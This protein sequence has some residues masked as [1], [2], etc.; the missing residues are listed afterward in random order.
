[1]KKVF[2]LFKYLSVLVFTALSLPLHAEDSDI[3][4]HSESEN[5][6]PSVY[7]STKKRVGDKFNI[8]SRA[9]NGA[10]GVIVWADGT[11]TPLTSRNMMIPLRS[12]KFKIEGRFE[13]LEVPG[14]KL[15]SLNVSE[16]KDLRYL[17]CPNNNL[18]NLDISNNVSLKELE[19][20]VNQI[21]SIDVSHNKELTH[22]LIHD[23]RLDTLDL[24]G[25]TKLERLVANSNLLKS[26]DI[27]KNPELSFL[28][29][30]ANQISTLVMDGNV[31]YSKL[32]TIYGNNNRLEILDL[33]G[34]PNL[35]E[36][37]VG[38]NLLRK[39]TLGNNDK[40]RKFQFDLN[41]IN[42]ENMQ[43]IVNS[44]NSVDSLSIKYISV[45]NPDDDNEGNICP[46][47]LVKE[48]SAKHWNVV[49]TNWDG[50]TLPFDGNS[51][52][53]TF[54]VSLEFNSDMGTISIEGLDS[55]A[56]AKVKYGTI[57]HVEAKGTKPDY[58]LK[59]LEANKTDILNDMQFKV[60]G[61]MKVVG[62]FSDFTSILEIAPTGYSVY[63]N[64]T[65]DY[66][67]IN[68]CANDEVRIFDLSGLKLADFVLDENG[69]ARF[70]F[71]SFEAGTYLVK[72]GRRILKVLVK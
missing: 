65:S 7:V 28:G 62:E 18:K 29:I 2:S 24:S 38:Q 30:R 70:D 48:L 41:S 51:P 34:C 27:S 8:A 53:D 36:V 68:G 16:Q 9:F 15:D 31:T 10:S 45:A 17:I 43:S 58:K 44:L 13:Y 42:E 55:E 14:N 26:L 12:R 20:G 60:V 5:T 49:Y 69:A 59:F 50:L 66:I 33:S 21:K 46:A 32:R 4:S 71:S 72:V 61:N 56:L 37:Y 25:N 63:P 3:T 6:V 19:C 23:C 64:P 35:K 57:L 39:I 11:K 54:S 40:L 1:M 67:K 22:L 47:S 52:N